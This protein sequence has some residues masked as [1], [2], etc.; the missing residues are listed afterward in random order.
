MCMHFCP[1]VDCLLSVC[2]FACRIMLKWV[3]ENRANAPKLIVS[4]L[5]TN[6]GTEV[7]YR[8][9]ELSFYLTAVLDLKT[10][11]K[12]VR[13]T[14]PKLDTAVQRVLQVLSRGCGN[15]I[16]HTLEVYCVDSLAVTHVL[17]EF[18]TGARKYGVSSMLLGKPVVESRGEQGI[19]GASRTG[20]L[21]NKSHNEE[22][23]NVVRS[24]KVWQK[25]KHV[26]F[27]LF[28]GHRMHGE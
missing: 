15:N 3:A 17:K 18:T 8:A 1:G 7:N 23:R 26:C 20:H 5:L 21:C 6:G 9:A 10:K 27:A 13:N 14:S 4:N 28:F 12:Y 22:T 11:Y 19:I 24:S 2:V 25:S 16:P